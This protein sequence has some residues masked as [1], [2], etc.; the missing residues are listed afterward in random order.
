MVILQ[1]VKSSFVT[2][3][4]RPWKFGEERISKLV[5]IGKGLRKEVFQKMFERYI[6]N[7]SKKLENELR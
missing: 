3:D 1:S 5:F 7:E 4:G 6:V 2:T